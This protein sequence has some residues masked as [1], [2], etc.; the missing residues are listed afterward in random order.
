MIPGFEA[1]VEERIRKAQEQ[2]ELENLPGQGK[3]LTFED[4]DIPED[5]RLAYKI[6]KNAGFLPPEVE[7]R[8]QI[9]ETETLLAAVEYDSPD[10]RRIQKRLN[11]LF[12]KLT[13]LRGG[14]E[15]SL[16]REIYRERIVKRML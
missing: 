7:V 5:M 9:H 16:Q 3:P 15:S 6:L 10:R 4:A 13:S 12:T 1:I 2:G 11:Y 14:S 8:K